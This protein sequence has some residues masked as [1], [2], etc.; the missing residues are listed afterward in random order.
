[1]NEHELIERCIKRDSQAQRILYD[2]YAPLMLSVCVR[3]VKDRE[4][5]EDLLQEGFIKVFTGIKKYSGTGEFGGW[6]RRIFVNTALQHLRDNK[7]LNAL[8]SISDYEEVLV[9]TDYTIVEKISADELLEHI[10]QLPDKYRIVFNLFA[11][12]GY[13]HK[14]IAE[15][16]HLEESTA[17]SRYLRARKALQESLTGLNKERN[18]GE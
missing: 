7:K 10:S 13:S 2:T 4:I 12:E 9:N 5:A 14:E 6:V 17:R 8:T 1:M 3:Y 11:I 15:I 16:L 18:A